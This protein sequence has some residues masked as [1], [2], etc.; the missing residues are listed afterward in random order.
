MSQTKT[1]DFNS[2]GSSYAQVVIKELDNVA[3]EVL[4]IREA[5]REKGQ[6]EEAMVNLK[7]SK[8]DEFRLHVI[9]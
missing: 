6:Q 5:I 2:Q 7:M 9:D 3:A 4:E 1:P 8:F